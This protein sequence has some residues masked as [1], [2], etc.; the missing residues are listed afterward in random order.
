MFC[1][2][3]K[4]KTS[5]CNW[6]EHNCFH[7]VLIPCTVWAVSWFIFFKD[8]LKNYFSVHDC[9]FV[10][11]FTGMRRKFIVVLR[12]SMSCL[13]VASSQVVSDMSLR[14]LVSLARG[15]V[16]RGYSCVKA[17]SG[18]FTDFIFHF[19]YMRRY[20]TRT[21]SNTAA[22]VPILY[23]FGCFSYLIIIFPIK[24]L[25]VWFTILHYYCIT[26]LL[27]NTVYML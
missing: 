14:I 19:C 12:E 24:A 25:A 3:G 15:Y 13:P 11:S 22:V 20:T 10:P 9:L 18:T 16:R 7:N 17:A 8:F 1:K 4:L 26:V 21:P 5:E 27:Y 2:A 23:M 6:T